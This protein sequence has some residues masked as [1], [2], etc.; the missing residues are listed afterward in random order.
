MTT[1]KSVIGYFR[2]FLAFFAFAFGVNG[3]GGV[4]SILRRTSSGEGGGLFGV[5]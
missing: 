4:F 3:C 2:V 5:A 1:H